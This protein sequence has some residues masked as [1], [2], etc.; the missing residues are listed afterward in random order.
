M[1]HSS[2]LLYHLVHRT[3]IEVTL[4]MITELLASDFWSRS[5]YDS[6]IQFLWFIEPSGLSSRYGFGN[7]GGSSYHLGV[8]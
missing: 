4:T 8:T 1:H 5:S 3:R 7:A 2:G 6:S